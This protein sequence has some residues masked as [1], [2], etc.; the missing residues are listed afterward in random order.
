M[1]KLEEVYPESL[2]LLEINQTD[3]HQFFY[4]TDETFYFI[5]EDDL[6]GDKIYQRLSI[7]KVYDFENEFEDIIKSYYFPNEGQSALD[8]LKTA[9]GNCLSDTEIEQ[10]IA[11]MISE[12]SY[13]VEFERFVDNY[14]DLNSIEKFITSYLK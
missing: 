10:L 11:E 7:F 8:A 12:Q 9:Y 5:E 1:K 14:S 4:K 2:D 6:P 3:E 13:S